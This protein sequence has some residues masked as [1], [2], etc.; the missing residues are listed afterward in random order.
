MNTH[1]NSRT[2]IASHIFLL[3]SEKGLSLDETAK[4]SGISRATLSRIEK[5]EVS[6]SAD[7]LGALCATFGI[8][9]SRLIARTEQDFDVLIPFENQAETVDNKTGFTCRSISPASPD[10][11]ACVEEGHL[12]PDR[13]LEVNRNAKPGQ[14]THLILLDGALSIRID[15]NEYDLTAGDCARYK[16]HSTVFVQTPP[17]RGARFLKIC[18]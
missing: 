6:P 16:Q 3:R 17:A 11:L 2:Q 1:A 14:E 18:V 15:Q 12:P 4:Q 13:H 5:A 10:L 9:V 8:P 7:T